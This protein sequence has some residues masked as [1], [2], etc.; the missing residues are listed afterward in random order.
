MTANTFLEALDLIEAEANN[1]VKLD[2]ISTLPDLL[3]ANTNPP[4]ERGLEVI[5][6]QN[7]DTVRNA[8]EDQIYR[9]IVVDDANTY[10]V[11]DYFEVGYVEANPGIKGNAFNSY[12]GVYYSDDGQ[13]TGE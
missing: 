1:Q 4:Y 13:D 5:A 12:V 10:Q 9:F 8:L 7:D 3:E 6:L 11:F 2:I